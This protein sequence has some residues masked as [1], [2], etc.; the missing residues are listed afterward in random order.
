MAKDQKESFICFQDWANYIMALPDEDALDLSRAIFAAGIGKEYTIKNDY[1]R[2]YFESVI[3][4]DMIANKEAREEYRQKQSD[5]GKKSAA[6]RANK[7]NRG[8]QRLT[9]VDSGQQSP[10][11]ST[12]N[13]DSNGDSNGDC[14]ISSNEQAREAIDLNE[15]IED[16]DMRKAL[17]SYI[18]VRKDVGRFPYM[19]ISAL[20]SSASAAE[21]KHGAPECIKIIKQAT[22]GGWKRV[23]WEDLDKD[24]ARS[25]T[26][27]KGSSWMQENQNV[28]DMDDL[29]SKLLEAQQ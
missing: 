10:A 17:A 25:G 23:P 3:L 8:Q 12:N 24:K 1:V 5:K 9:V 29:E 28:Y 21:R 4:P 6:T 22:E 20:L 2:I 18:E 14:Y 26:T 15:V 13:G 27:K 11:N 19:A 16:S 7:S